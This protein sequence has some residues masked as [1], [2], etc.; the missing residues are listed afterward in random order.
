MAKH[1]NRKAHV[2]DQERKSTENM[3]MGGN[4]AK[5]FMIGAE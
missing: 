2:L 4:N 3:K 1:E 5:E